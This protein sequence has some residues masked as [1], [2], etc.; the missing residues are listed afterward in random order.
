MEGLSPSSED[1]SDKK[2][3]TGKK[4]KSAEA[5]GAI[6]VEPKSELNVRAEQEEKP[7]SLWQ[8]LVGGEPKAAIEA[9]VIS[10]TTTDETSETAP[11]KVESAE[12]LSEMDSTENQYAVHE[13]V[14]SN[15]E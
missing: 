3:S 7:E 13:I 9:K 4:K 15:K 11:E 12:P 14:R 1:D 8:R 10:E 6:V 2:E 5:I